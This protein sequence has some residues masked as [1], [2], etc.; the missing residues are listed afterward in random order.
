MSTL[1]YLHGFNSSPRSAK[2]SLLKNWLAEHHPNV[3]MI[4][5]QC[6]VLNPSDVQNCWHPLSWKMACD[7]LGIVGLSLGN[8]T[9]PVVQRL[10]L[11]AV[12][13][14]PAVRP[15]ELLDLII[16]VRTYTL[17]PAAICARVTRDSRIE[18][19]ADLLAGVLDSRS[20]LSCNRREMK[21]W[22]TA[23]RWR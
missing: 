15:F 20:A 18:S 3:Q 21:C 2:A 8:I 6:S 23:R 13:V 5:L 22:I 16:P 7:L 12:V 9:P 11:P 10:T 19:H 14:N 17:T 4:I 1:L